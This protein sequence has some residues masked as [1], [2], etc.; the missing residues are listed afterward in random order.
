[1]YNVI[2]GGSFLC[3]TEVDL[4]DV[5]SSV[6]IDHL[7]SKLILSFGFFGDR[8]KCSIVHIADI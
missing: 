1:M 3:G 4:G 6:L 7:D 8:S 2:G 5:C